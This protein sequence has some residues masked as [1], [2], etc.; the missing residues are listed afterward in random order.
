[1]DLW[2]Y[3]SEAH[4]SGNGNLG[5]KTSR[6]ISLLIGLELPPP[7]IS[8]FC[9]TYKCDILANLFILAIISCHDCLKDYI[10][11]ISGGKAGSN[12]VIV[13]IL[14]SRK[15]A[16][17]TLGPIVVINPDFYWEKWSFQNTEICNLVKLPFLHS[18]LQKYVPNQLKWEKNSKITK[19][20]EKW[21]LEPSR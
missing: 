15:C 19:N 6:P 5:P 12:L 10:F 14:S 20:C 7:E 16:F 21:H 11:P 18:K 9:T 1:L 3:E 8:A 17:L 2:S 13:Y 4:F